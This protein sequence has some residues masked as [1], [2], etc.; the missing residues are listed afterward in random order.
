M[1]A[2]PDFEGATEEKSFRPSF[3]GLKRF[4]EVLRVAQMPQAEPLDSAADVAVLLEAGELYFED[5]DG[6]E[7]EPETLAG[8]AA[9][10]ILLDDSCFDLS[11]TLPA[12]PLPELDAMIRN[13]LLRASPFREEDARAFWR[14]NETKG[15]EWRVH[16]GVVL[17]S[18]L[19][20]VQD[21]MRTYGFTLN[22]IVRLGASKAFDITAGPD[23]LTHE[24]PE[25]DFKPVF[26]AAARLPLLAFGL[27]A[28]SFVG[29]FALTSLQTADLR[30]QAFAADQRIQA[31]ASSAGFES[32]VAGKLARSSQ[33]ISMLA[34]LSAQLPDGTWLDR[35]AIEEDTARIIGFGPSGAETIRLLSGLDGVENVRFVSPVTRDNSQGLER[36]VIEFDLVR[37]AR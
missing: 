14:A 18:E 30:D 19:A 2:T 28:L 27:F 22:R 7:I 26:P 10:L 13:E 35:F 3:D 15:G 12:A 11:F 21:A 36:F 6:L 34:T 16:A 17:K 24:T 32:A 9:D 4:R 29:H 33:N 37:T 23:W 5:S 25:T 31:A 8:Q 1:V 20:L